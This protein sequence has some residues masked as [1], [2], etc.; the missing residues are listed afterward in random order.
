M[1]L[2]PHHILC[3]RFFNI[4]PPGRGGDFENKSRLIRI[5]MSSAEGPAIE[6]TRGVDELCAACPSLGE[7]GCVSPFGDEEKVGRWD[8]RVMQGL[9]IAYG[10]VKTAGELRRLIDSKRPLTFCKERCPW[11][12]ICAVFDQ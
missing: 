4:E 12:S 10:E 11:R 2:R 1:K 3:V 7:G 5:M 9:G 8:T 6:I